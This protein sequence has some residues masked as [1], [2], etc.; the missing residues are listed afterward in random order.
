MNRP[1]LTD[2]DVIKLAVQNILPQVVRWHR[3]GGD[4]SQESEIANDLRE[5]IGAH[6]D[7]YEFCRELERAKHWSC[8]SE[9]VH[10]LDGA[11]LYGALHAIEAQWVAAYRVFPE[12]LPGNRVTWKGHPATIL[13]S[14]AGCHAGRDGDCIWKDC[15]QLRDNEPTATGRHC[16]LDVWRDED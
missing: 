8:D 7:G 3:S 16:P 11:D 12:Q 13:G 14:S 15:P 2:P 9:L 5:E 6:Q 10:I 4:G 1:T